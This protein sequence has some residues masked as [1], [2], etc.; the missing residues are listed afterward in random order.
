M[1]IGKSYYLFF[2]NSMD[3]DSK[4]IKGQAWVIDNQLVQDQIVMYPGGRSTSNIVVLIPDIWKDL[5]APMLNA[6]NGEDPMSMPG[7]GKYRTNKKGYF[8]W[9]VEMTDIGDDDLTVKVFI[10]CPKPREEDY[11]K[12]GEYSGEWAEY[13]AERYNTALKNA[14]DKMVIQ[15]KEVVFPGSQYLDQNGDWVEVKEKRE[16]N[17]E[18]GSIANLLSMF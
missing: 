10:E 2:L 9:E 14:E 4:V 13:W 7:D 16:T 1:T 8:Y 6:G 17:Y 12:L 5:Q 3:E 11:D 15:K 18:L